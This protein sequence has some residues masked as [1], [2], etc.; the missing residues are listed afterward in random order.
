MDAQLFNQFVHDHQLTPLQAQRMASTLKL[1][2]ST[3]FTIQCE[4]TGC[5]E[6]FTLAQSHSYVMVY[7][8]TGTTGKPS[9]QCEHEQHYGCSPACAVSAAIMCMQDHLMPQVQ[10]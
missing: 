8:T 4:G 9:F 6:Q 7:A 2:P 5:K 10:N 1:D 3:A